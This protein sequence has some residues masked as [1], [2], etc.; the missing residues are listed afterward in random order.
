MHEAVRFS[1]YVAVGLSA[2]AV[3]YA[4]ASVSIDNGMQAELATALGTVAGFVVSWLGHS[5]V[6]FSDGKTTMQSLPIL[7][8]TAV[9]AVLF[10]SIVVWA[11]M[12][13][14]SGPRLAVIL[15]I[16]LTPAV[17]YLILRRL[18]LSATH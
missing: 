1:R 7:L 14:G 13:I 4:T 18:L 5:R 6:T 8:G 17:N 9:F 3:H 15:G 11:A 16:A 10:N 12:G 2:A